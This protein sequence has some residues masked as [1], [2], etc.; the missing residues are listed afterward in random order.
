MNSI[1][2]SPIRTGAAATAMP[3]P[4]SS[5]STQ[6][7]PV[8]I[9]ASHFCHHY[10]QAD[11]DCLFRAIHRGLANQPKVEASRKQVI[12][13]RQELADYVYRHQNALAGNPAFEGMQGVQNLYGLLL[14][15]GHWNHNAGDLV[16][17]LFAQVYGR[18]VTVMQ[19]NQDGSAYQ[20]RQTFPAE[21]STLPP[22]A[23]NTNEPP[24]YLALNDNKHYGYLE[25]HSSNS[26]SGGLVSEPESSGTNSGS[27]GE[28][29]GVGGINDVPQAFRF[30]HQ[31]FNS[32]KLT[33]AQET[34]LAQLWRDNP[35]LGSVAVAREFN[36]RNPEA[37]ISNS[38]PRALK[39][40]HPY[41]QGLK[42]G[43]EKRERRLSE[44]QER[45]LATL[46]RE[47]SNWPTSQV[48]NEFNQRYPQI[49]ISTSVVKRV[50][51]LQ[52]SILNPPRKEEKFNGVKKK[53][54]LQLW[55]DNP[56]WGNRK[57]AHEFMKL[58][59]D[60]K[61]SKSMSS[62]LK[63]M[64]PH[65]RDLGSAMNVK[66]LRS[67]HEKAFVQLWRDNPRWEAIRVVREF[68]QRN[69]GVEVKARLAWKLKKSHPD[70]QGLKLGEKAHLQR[71]R[72]DQTAISAPPSSDVQTQGEARPM[73]ANTTLNQVSPYSQ[74]YSMDEYNSEAIA[75]L[76]Q[77]P[78][79]PM[80]W[81]NEPSFL[82]DTFEPSIDNQ[83]LFDWISK[84]AEEA[85]LPKDTASASR[86]K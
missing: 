61:V 48:A 68:S 30:D 33:E 62:K 67:E 85:E 12:A 84:I 10:V 60:L 35:G 8:S 27:K 41:L 81:F 47:K 3:A 55:Q 40:S 83:N 78:L 43:G 79:E 17:P 34:N 51:R 38:I 37:N 74:G 39:Y 5:S 86:D 70:L 4:A 24:I 31:K 28:F 23:E 25:P 16:P 15:Q 45:E 7:A 53:E 56:K 18:A 36:K 11:G 58:N 59:P 72:G 1:N 14:T 42:L 57:I 50:K 22:W 29:D 82:E 80:E 71:A 13:I 63:K 54:L 21:N 44:A 20:V 76:L 26:L 66:Q 65:L 49:N 69:P 77:E 64:N 19:A 32:K 2:T 52:E 46:F 75:A 73:D 6:A 9:P